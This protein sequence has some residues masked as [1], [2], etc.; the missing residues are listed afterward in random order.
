MIVSGPPPTRYRAEPLI[1]AQLDR[2]SGE[3]GAAEALVADDRRFTWSEVRERSRRLARALHAVGIRRGDHVAAW[4]PNQPEWLF[5]WLATTYLGAVLVPVNTRYRAEEVRYILRQSDTRLL[6]LRTSFLDVDYEA[7]LAR[8]WPSDDLPELERVAAVGGASWEELLARADEVGEDELDEA[9]AAVRPDDPTI[10]VYTSGTT[11]HPKGAVH[12][13]RILRNECSIAEW[14]GIEPGSRTL[15]HM[16][17]FHVAGGLSATLPAVISGGALVLMD[18]WSPTRALEL[19]ERERISV[20]GGTPTHFIDLLQHPDRAAYD[21]SSLE[22][23]WIGGA[24]NPRWVIE[25]ALNELGMAHLFPVYGM[26][27]TTSATTYPRADDPLDVVLSGKGVPI[28][29]FELKVAARETGAELDPGLEGEVCVRGHVVMQGYYRNPEAT[30]AVLD[31]DGWFHTGDLGVLD[32][33]GY[34]AITGRVSD[35]F[36]VGGANA[37]PAE[38]EQAL[39]EH[40]DVVLA[41]VVGIPHERLGEIGVAFVERRQGS[42]LAAEDVL[43]FARGR[44]ANYK[45]PHAVHFVEDWPRTATGKIQRFVLRERAVVLSDFPPLTG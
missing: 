26:T 27:E 31:A 11:G 35:M 16:P 3:R 24:N 25:G 19:I 41:S 20:F 15:G 42:T 21:L 43:A 34:L 12:S 5:A 32:A 14:L 33:D 17:F 39:A 44:L 13:H 8:L 38:I 40:P 6:L 36:I 18:R 9:A 1:S 30:A 28:S 45:V 7:M 22:T 37:Y 29:D 4:L 10:I 23:G 2:T